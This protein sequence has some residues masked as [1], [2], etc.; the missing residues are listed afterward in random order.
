MNEYL[1]IFVSH[2]WIEW[3]SEDI[4][5][6]TINRRN[7][8]IFGKLKNNKR[9]FK[10]IKNLIWLS[11]FFNIF[12]GDLIHTKEK[13]HKLAKRLDQ[14]LIRWFKRNK[15]YRQC[16]YC[17]IYDNFNCIFTKCL[18]TLFPT[19][20]F[21]RGSHGGGWNPPPLWKIHFGVSEPN[22]FLHSQLYIYKELRSKRI[23]S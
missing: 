6:I 3:I 9:I 16:L 20:Y 11:E 2:K 10:I 15:K 4:H 1:N 8:R 18:L 14:S 21:F 22:S 23:F 13:G 7:I 12:N 19:A 17:C 5:A